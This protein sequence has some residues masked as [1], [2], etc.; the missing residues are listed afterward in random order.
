MVVASGSGIPISILRAPAN[1]HESTLAAPA[2]RNIRDLAR[3]VDVIAPH[4]S[5]RKKTQDG[6]KLRR[7]KR[8]W[9][10]ERTNS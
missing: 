2:L 1:P 6:P 9:I 4:V 7:Y 8:C 3:G 10:I 5:N